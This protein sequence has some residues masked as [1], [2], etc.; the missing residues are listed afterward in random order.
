MNIDKG[1]WSVVLNDDG[2]PKDTLIT[3]FIL[4]I[5]HDGIVIIRSLSELYT[6][7]QI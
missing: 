2:G 7:P 3:P 5:T 1:A 4:I 6:R